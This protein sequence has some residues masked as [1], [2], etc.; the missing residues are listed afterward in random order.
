MVFQ[1][2]RQYD[3]RVV[4]AKWTKTLV[5]QVVVVGAAI[6]QAN[7]L[8]N[9][10]RLGLEVV[11]ADAARRILRTQPLQLAVDPFSVAPGFAG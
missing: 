10:P 2:G 9:H 4:K 7:E 3:M 8:G 11:G 5:V 6:D 1:L